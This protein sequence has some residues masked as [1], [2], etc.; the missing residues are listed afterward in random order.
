ME[1]SSMP[2]EEKLPKEKK[3]PN[4]RNAGCGCRLLN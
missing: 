1:V 2:K 4:T 3:P